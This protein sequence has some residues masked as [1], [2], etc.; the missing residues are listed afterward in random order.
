MTVI[1]KDV[2]SSLNSDFDCSFF[3]W[4]A[5][6]PINSLLIAKRDIFINKGSSRQQ[7]T[8]CVFGYYIFEERLD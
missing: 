6:I 5:V 3:K 4:V 2:C 1:R 8:C 7:R